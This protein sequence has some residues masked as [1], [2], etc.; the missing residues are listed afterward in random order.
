M[1]SAPL[2]EKKADG[3]AIQVSRLSG[4]IKGHWKKDRN[5]HVISDLEFGLQDSGF[6]GFRL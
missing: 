1:A 4:V 3:L 5:P 2:L 6:L